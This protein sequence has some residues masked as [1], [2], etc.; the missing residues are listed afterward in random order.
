MQHDLVA[1]RDAGTHRQRLAMVGMQHAAILDI[2]FLSDANEIYITSHNGLKP[3]R[4]VVAHDY[5]T[6]EG[7]IFCQKAIFT[8]FWGKFA[9]RND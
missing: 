4:A 7:G 6:N 2:G 5:I 3:D 9:T 8:P 1:H